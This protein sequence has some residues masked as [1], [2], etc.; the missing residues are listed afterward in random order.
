MLYCYSNNKI[1]FGI[2]EFTPNWFSI[3]RINNYI[4]KSKNNFSYW[5]KS[6]YSISYFFLI[7]DSILFNMIHDEIKNQF[8]LF[9]WSNKVN[10]KFGVYKFLIF[11]EILVRNCALIFLEHHQP[12]QYGWHSICIVQNRKDLKLWTRI[13]MK[14]RNL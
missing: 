1:L 5:I 4:L 10:S 11:S 9:P 2:I 7:H 14:T 8:V 13:S 12:T 6:I 3:C